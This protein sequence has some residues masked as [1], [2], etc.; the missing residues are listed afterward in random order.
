M[1]G[2]FT[3][4][5]VYPAVKYRIHI[6]ALFFFLLVSSFEQA[7]QPVIWPAVWAFSAWHLALYLFDRAYDYDKDAI[8]Q[9]QE[10][11]RPAERN[12]WLSVSF[13]LA[14]APLLI[15]NA[16]GLSV[17]PYLPFVP[18]TFLYTFPV[19]RGL[20]AKNLFL[21]KNLYSALLIWTMP[22]A[23]VVFAYSDSGRTFGSLFK[24]HFLGMFLY[25]LVGEAFW[26]I[27]DI[28]SDQVHGV[29]TIPAVFGILPTKAY[30]L[31]LVLL[32]VLV[33]G[34]PVGDS[35]IVY[36]A[37]IA[38][39]GRSTPNWVYHLPALLALYRFVKPLAVRATQGLS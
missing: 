37:L 31:S 38:L 10:A 30:L 3:D 34:R 5:L 35:A 27:R 36:T 16:S 32:D 13:I 28:E 4:V 9:P 19:Y 26:D 15:L 21:I 11:I 23:V 7:G 20:R 39:V 24:A 25:V 8:S 33:F 14:A 6:S 18:V 29:R 12:L 17:L 2:T 22:L 1:S